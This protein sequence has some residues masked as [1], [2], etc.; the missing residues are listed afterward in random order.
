M[1]EHDV[2]E[3]AKLIVSPALAVDTWA[4][5]DPGPES[6]Q[7]MTDNVAALATWAVSTVSDTAEN[8]TTRLARQIRS[9]ERVRF[10][11]TPDL[12]I[13][14]PLLFDRVAKDHDVIRGTWPASNDSRRDGSVG[15]SR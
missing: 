9:P 7:L 13:I 5:N 6:L 15:L 2:T 1:G 11:D 3:G 10:R 12:R 4:R 8:A 14:S